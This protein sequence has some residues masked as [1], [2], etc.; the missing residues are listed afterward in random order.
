VLV[1]LFA[2]LLIFDV[3]GAAMA[4]LISYDELS[5]HYADRRPPL[6][7]ATRRGTAALI[8]LVALSGIVALVVR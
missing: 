4:F 6:L 1:G 8:F 5:R 7:E 3:L 2:L